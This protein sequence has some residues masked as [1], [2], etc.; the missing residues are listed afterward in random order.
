MNK[1]AV[2]ER[3]VGLFGDIVRSAD[4]WNTYGYKMDLN[5]EDADDILAQTEEAAEE[6]TESLTELRELLE[7]LK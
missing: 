4:I 7:G 6:I 1:Q 2:A 5:D 3:M